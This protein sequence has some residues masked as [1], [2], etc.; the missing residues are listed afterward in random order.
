MRT[1]YFVAQPPA[2]TTALVVDLTELGTGARAPGRLVDLA[3]LYAAHGL[4]W[5]QRFID[6][7]GA[8]NIAN[9][10]LEWWAYTA[11]AKNLLSSSLGNAYI[12]ALALASVVESLE[13][14]ALYVVGATRAQIEYL[15]RRFAGNAGIRLISRR[16]TLASA[17]RWL[18]LPARL[19]YHAG[20]IWTASLL[21]PRKLAPPPTEADICLFTYFDVHSADHPDAYF[22]EL[23][24]AAGQADSRRRVVFTGFIHG[25][26]SATLTRLAAFTSRRCWPLFLEARIS[27]LLWACMRSLAALRV[28]RYA[29]TAGS[30]ADAPALEPLLRD[31][32]WADI[33]SGAYFQHLLV[34]RCATRFG[35]RFRPSRLIYPFENKSLEKMLLL[36]L[37]RSCPG[38]EICGYQH[39]SVTPRHATL[40]FSRGEADITPLPQRIVTVGTVTRDYLEA[41]GNYPPGLLRTG[42]AL[43]QQR[44]EAVPP[45]PAANTK[46][47][48]LLALSSSTTELTR[49]VQF[50]R[51]AAELGDSFELGIRPHPEFPLSRLPRALAD[52]VRGHAL[53]FSA[54]ALAENIAWCDVTAYVS[55]TVAL[56]TLMA[57]KPVVNI[58]IL[59]ELPSDPV[60]GPAP[61]H[62]RART[63]SDFART[64]K[65]IASLKP[66]DRDRASAGARAYIHDYLRPV[67]C[68]CLALLLENESHQGPGRN[69]SASAPRDAPISIVVPVRDEAATLPAL[70]AALEAQTAQPAQ[71]IFVDTGSSD[72]SRNIIRNWAGAGHGGG[73]R[74]LLLELD[75]AFPGAARNAGIARATQPWIAF[76]DA[77]V[78]PESNWLQ[79]LLD[80]VVHTEL[81]GAFG[82]TG[83]AGRNALT[84]ALCALSYGQDARRPTLPGSLFR[85]DAIDRVGG[86]DASLR[87]GEDIVWLNR[88]RQAYPGQPVQTNARTTY[89]HFPETWSAAAGKWFEYERHLARARL[90]GWLPFVHIAAA[91]AAATVLVIDAPTGFTLLLLYW[92]ARGVADPIRRSAHANWWR[93]HPASALLALPSA[94]VI[95]AAKVAGSI[96]GVIER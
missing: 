11:T 72:E 84:T 12:Q 44:R 94:V 85:K 62:W 25:A 15:R 51:S 19:A 26:F 27:D 6:W 86:F 24:L 92:V 55:S 64:L 68:D 34:Y 90:T 52:W 23:A 74:A 45:A 69:Q 60:L 20:R 81:A 32:F 13:S 59:E 57:G 47:R 31:A 95:D 79:T 16:V 73:A 61:F 5:R 39:T 50:L 89:T 4:Q 18:A 22:G 71:L 1:V 14:G 30:D 93:E 82:T 8:V 3:P 65:D 49:S 21:G 63:P 54:T 7:L 67:S 35:A 83:F 36:G 88:F 46:P 58:G 40:L 29:L 96:V 41:H 80:T 33:R 2:A 66:A 48:V 42:C 87:A 56:E 43:R 17:L 77:G 70:L 28:G 38:I 75:G 53:D 37:R 78:T 91:V 10:G 9:A 76:L